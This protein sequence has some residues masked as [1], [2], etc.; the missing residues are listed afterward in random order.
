MRSAPE[1]R[2]YLRIIEQS[3]SL[4]EVTMTDAQITPEQE[5]MVATWEAHMAAEFASHDLQATMSTMAPEP[6]VNHVAVMTGGVGQAAVRDFYANHFLPAHPR[7]TASTLIARTVG[8]D[9]IVE[10]LEF[11]FTHDI[12][13]PWILPGVE[14]TGR[15]IEIA[16]AAVV[17]FEGGRIAGERI[18]WDQASVLVQA[19]LLPADTLP[20]T[21]AE[22]VRKAAD[23]RSEPSNQLI[24]RRQKR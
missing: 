1:P 20:V 17:L 5:L 12:D 24:G 14:P 2:P 7:D 16:V 15:H 11:S 21:G 22:A 13:M 23:P 18:Y 10:E 3:L 9:R 6:F 4:M 8:A 19:G